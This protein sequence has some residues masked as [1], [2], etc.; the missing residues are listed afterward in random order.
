MNC[1]LAIYAK[2]ISLSQIIVYYYILSENRI[3]F[4]YND[5]TTI[6]M[7]NMLFF[8]FFR[9]N[10][11]KRFKQL[12]RTCALL[13]IPGWITGMPGCKIDEV[14]FVSSDYILDFGELKELSKFI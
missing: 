12:D 5:L 8:E 1:K 2:R 10:F 6:E 4:E 9:F 14:F 13:N 3:M 11:S 7:N